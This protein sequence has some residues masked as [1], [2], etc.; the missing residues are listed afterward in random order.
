VL[1]EMKGAERLKRLP[2]ANHLVL[3]PGDWT[4]ELAEVASILQLPVL[5]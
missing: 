5:S 3:V 2:L 4:K 1:L